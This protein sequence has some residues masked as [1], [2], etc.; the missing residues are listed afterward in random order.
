[1]VVQLSYVENTELYS[2]INSK[3]TCPTTTAGLLEIPTSA[4]FLKTATAPTLPFGESTNTLATY[5]AGLK[6]TGVIPVRPASGADSA[7][8]D[9]AVAQLKAEYDH[10]YER[11]KCAITA[12]LAAPTD[13]AAKQAVITLNGRLY[14][15]LQIYE[16][17]IEETDMNISALSEKLKASIADIKAQ[18]DVM[19]A[20]GAANEQLY[21]KMMEHAKEK[22]NVSNNLLNLYAFLN[23]VGIGILFYI[24]RST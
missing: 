5:Y 9:A 18:G 3:M 17:M 10:F 16:K 7:D 4:K 24:Y 12:H 11:Y 15:L 14:A 2:M 23:I 13:D 21:R 22:A 8:F 20:G 1:M 6:S 19:S